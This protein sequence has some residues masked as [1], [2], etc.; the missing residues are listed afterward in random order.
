MAPNIEYSQADDGSDRD[1]VTSELSTQDY[2]VSLKD[3]LLKA[4]DN[5]KVAG[6][7]ASFRKLQHRPPAGLHV[8]GVGDIS[9][10]LGETQ[11]RQLIAKARQAPYG[12]GSETIVDTSVRNTW[13]LDAAQFTFN[14]QRWPGYIQSV[15]AKVAADLGIKSPIR[16]EIY[17]MLI[18]E[19]GAMFKSHTDT[20]KIPGQFGT[21]VIALP[22]AHKGGDVVVKHCGET[23]TFK[24]SEYRQSFICWYSDVHHKVC[25][26]ESGYRWVLTYNLAL[27]PNAVRPS[28][29]LVRSETKALRHTLR[30]WLQEPEESRQN[31]LYYVLDHDYTEASINLN[32]LKTRDL[33]LGQVLNNVSKELDFEVFFALLEKEEFGETEIDHDEYDRGSRYRGWGEDSE[34]EEEEEESYHHL[35]EILDV[36]YQVKTVR[37]MHGR[38]VVDGLALYAEKDIL[39]N[40]EDAYDDVFSGVEPEE[41]YEGYMGNFVSTSCPFGLEHSE[42]NTNVPTQQGPSATHWYRI[43]VGILSLSYLPLASLNVPITNCPLSKALLLV[44]SASIFEF[45]SSNAQS[46]FSSNN[47]RSLISYCARSSMRYMESDEHRATLSFRAV[48]KLCGS[49]W[50]PSNERL[51]HRSKPKAIDGNDLVNILT[52]AL[53]LGE[54]DFF[55]E[56]CMMHGDVLPTSF[57]T[58]AKQWLKESTSDSDFDDIMEQGYV[59]CHQDH[60]WMMNTN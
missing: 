43:T 15:C 45:F 29:G 56:A 40:G 7:F 51:G 54:Y 42:A 58:W 48:T 4:L 9:M 14:N 46:L 25:P 17:K 32:S 36:K 21:L 53:E 22:S 8:D 27:N 41:E 20:E 50:Y 34:E 30:K 60:I 39:Q 3:D 44:P 33:A 13:E 47:L 26:V 31:G 6:S 57:F 24:T 49:F 10:P 11:A 35:E 28:A 38:P 5:V 18:Y 23:K 52:A 1:S 55:E 12:R 2:T 37:D 19:R 59:L 16:A